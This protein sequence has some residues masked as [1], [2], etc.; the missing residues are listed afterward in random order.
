MENEQ[1]IETIHLADYLK[2]ILKRKTLIISFL[3]ITV[4][5]VLFM[6]LLSPSIYKATS[7]VVID[8]ESFSSPLTGRRTDYASYLDEQLTFNTHFELIKSKPVILE[9]IKDMDAAAASETEIDEPLSIPARIKKQIKS[10]IRLLKDNVKL[11]IGKESKE[12]SPEE[13]LDLKV[14]ALQ[15][16]I[17]IQQIPETRLVAIS[18]RGISPIMVSELANSVAKN[19]IEFDMGSR[20]SS[21][22][23]SLEW[24]NNEMYRLKKRLEDD[25]KKFHEYKQLNKVFSVKGKQQVISQKIAEFNNEYLKARNKRQELDAQLNQIASLRAGS[26]GDIAHIRSIINNP[27]IDAIYKNLTTLELEKTRLSKVYKGK[28]PKVVQNTGEI[29][30]NKLKLKTELQKEVDNLKSERSVLQAKERVLEQNI[31]EFERDA[32]DA[33]GKELRYT[34]LQRNLDTSQNLYDT[35]VAKIKES[36]VLSSGTESN[37]RIVEKAVVPLNPIGP[38]KKKNLLFALIVGLFG[39]VGLAFFLEY[40]DQSVRTEEDVVNY[41]EVPVLSLIPTA[42]IHDTKRAY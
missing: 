32:L 30:R 20:L 4:F 38:N 21:S 26:D 1:H 31:S 33:S 39:G 40:I 14:K 3:V 11:L 41:L 15:G 37:I 16:A 34:I 27:A 12:I 6:T 2:V 8:R 29:E 17:Q 36:G 22:K 35:L 42:D 9:V 13:K 24:M 7:Q 10:N 28:H 25:E 23:D 19:Y 18:V 5:L